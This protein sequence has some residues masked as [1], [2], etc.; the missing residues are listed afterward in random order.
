M[1]DALSLYVA[2][3]ANAVPCYGTG[4][5]TQ[6]LLIHGE[7][8]GPGILDRPGRAAGCLRYQY[9]FPALTGPAF[10]AGLFQRFLDAFH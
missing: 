5:F 7:G 9:R 2:G 6:D 4:G 8:F 10:L 3:V 1:I